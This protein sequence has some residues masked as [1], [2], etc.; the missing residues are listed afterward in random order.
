MDL[1]GKVQPP[2]AQ[3]GQQPLSPDAA[4]HEPRLLQESGIAARV[5]VLAAP[6]LADLGLRLVRVKISGQ[7]GTTVQ[8]M[9]ERPDGTMDVE[10]CE[11]VSEALSP[12]LDV[13]DPVKQAYHLEISSPGIDRPLVRLSDFE[14]ALGQEVRV[15]LK[16]GLAGRKRF[17][18]T[19][20]PIEA[21]SPIGGSKGALRL[22]RTDAKP[23]EETEVLLPLDDLHE[24][25]LVLTEDLIRQALRAAK[26]AREGDDGNNEEQDEEQEEPAPPRR[27]PGRF[28]PRHKTQN[29]EH[30]PAQN[31]ISAR[32]KPLVPAGVR[33]EFKKSKTGER[34]PAQKPHLASQAARKSD[35]GS[36]R[37]GHDMPR[38]PAP[39]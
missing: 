3:V 11:S 10:A 21:S 16:T 26:A 27:G 37:S 22:T 30:N 8:I 6:V 24:A 17:R 28:A 14:R 31:P 39:K 36:S 18:G 38:K 32:A 13:E 1:D 33:T 5:A 20:G 4:L 23:E 7:N 9:A 15:E 34:G 35:T 19:I 12:V 29:P 2:S 25:R